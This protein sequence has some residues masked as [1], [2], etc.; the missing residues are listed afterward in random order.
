MEA[1]PA[2]E[3]QSGMDPAAWAEVRRILEAELTKE[4]Q[5]LAEEHRSCNNTE[6]GENLQ[7]SGPARLGG[8]PWI[9]R[10]RRPVGDSWGADT[11]VQ[12]QPPLE[13]WALELFGLDRSI[14]SIALVA[15]PPAERDAWWDSLLLERWRPPERRDKPE[16]GGTDD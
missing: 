16:G 7:K 9:P 2:S 11:R 8:L 3:R 13:Q 6:T 10:Q 5:G 12:H 1:V 15:V 4:A 14:L